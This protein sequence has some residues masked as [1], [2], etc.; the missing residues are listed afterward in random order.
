MSQLLNKRIPKPAVLPGITTGMGRG[1][2]I[3]PQANNGG[4][5]TQ[6]F[7]RMEKKLGDAFEVTSEKYLPK[8]LPIDTIPM[9]M[10]S[11]KTDL[12]LTVVMQI[13]RPKNCDLPI[14]NS[15]TVAALL[16]VLQKVHPDTYLAPTDTT[17]IN[18]DILNPLDVPPTDAALDQYITYEPDLPSNTMM[19]RLFFRSNH[20]LS[21]YKKDE[22]VSKYMA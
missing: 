18:N 16:A 3:T 8:R 10:H 4:W 21:E 17:T 15:R 19:G 5:I 7:K 6:G 14:H 20:R 2:G 22:Q 12:L 11:E 9:A 1:G 13:K